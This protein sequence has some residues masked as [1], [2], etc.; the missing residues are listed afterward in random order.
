M[1]VPSIQEK[2]TVERCGENVDIVLAVVSL[3]LLLTSLRLDF[4]FVSSDG[5]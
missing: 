4:I 3:T 1:V 5:P 2:T